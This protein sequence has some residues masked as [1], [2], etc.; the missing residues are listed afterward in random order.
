MRAYFGG[1]KRD[2]LDVRIAEIEG[3]LMRLDERIRRLEAL[4]RDR[5]GE[6]D[7]LRQAIRDNG[8]DRITALDREIASG[9]PRSRCPPPNHDC[10]SQFPAMRLTEVRPLAANSG[11][12][13]NPIGDFG[14]TG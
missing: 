6:R 11:T 13:K 10:G 12:T 4:G 7:S 5:E 8:G 1:L 9:T 14:Q 2:L 3:E